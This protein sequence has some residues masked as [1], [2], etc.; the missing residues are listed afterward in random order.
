MQS[1]ILRSP[2]TVHSLDVWFVRSFVLPLLLSSENPA[3]IASAS[4]ILR[5]PDTPYADT[6][7]H[8]HVTILKS[9][10]KHINK[11]KI[12]EKS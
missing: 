1:F 3:I 7:L 6:H 12:V 5:S 2:D 11:Q 4:F 9:L 10:L 8:C